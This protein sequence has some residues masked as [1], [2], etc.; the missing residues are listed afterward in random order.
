MHRHGVEVLLT[1]LFHPLTLSV[2]VV[3]IAGIA[4][5]LL[6]FQLRWMRLSE[7]GAGLSG[8]KAISTWMFWAV[9]LGGLSS[10]TSGAHLHKLDSV[11]NECFHL[12]LAI[13]PALLVLV[14]AGWVRATRIVE[15]RAE[16]RGAEEDAKRETWWIMVA[17]GT[18]AAM[19]VLHVP[20]TLTPAS[21]PASSPTPL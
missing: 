1:Y 17:A 15:A 4:S 13:F 2:G 6:N 3:G 9:T 20:F 19:S 14:G 11:L 21:G 7:A 5:I 10:L 18:A 8:P 16:S 12:V